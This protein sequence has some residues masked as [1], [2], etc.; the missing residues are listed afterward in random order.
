MRRCNRTNSSGESLCRHGDNAVIESPVEFE[1]SAREERQR[2]DAD[3][4]G[5]RFVAD[6]PMMI[7]MGETESRGASRRTGMGVKL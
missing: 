7:A 6:T 1:G 2:R 5:P 4:S 3:A